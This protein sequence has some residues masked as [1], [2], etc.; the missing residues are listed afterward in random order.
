MQARQ[1]VTL[2]G[3]IWVAL[4]AQAFV[5]GAGAFLITTAQGMPKGELFTQ[6]QAHSPL[7]GFVWGHYR[8]GAGIQALLSPLVVYS[9]FMFLQRRSW[10]RVMLQ[11]LSAGHLILIVFIL[12]FWLDALAFVTSRPDQF[13]FPI[14]I[15]FI[16]SIMG[17]VSML[18]FAFGFGLCL[19]TLN[20]P[21]VKEEFRSAR[22]TA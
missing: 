15:R 22:Q 14:F 20:R 2:I 11:V 18:P 7:M 10:A 6:L 19:W 16:M 9:A 12:I 21:D 1:K 17:V 3:W 13:P 5:A 8:T 4:G